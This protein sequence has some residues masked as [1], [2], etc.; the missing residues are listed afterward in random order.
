MFF[1]GRYRD[2]LFISFSAFIFTLIY[3]NA[4]SYYL[5]PPFSYRELYPNI[6]V[7]L[8]LQIG[9]GLQSILWLSLSY[10]YSLVSAIRVLKLGLSLVEILMR[11]SVALFFLIL[12][13]PGLLHMTIGLFAGFV[14][15]LSGQTMLLYYVY[16]VITIAS[17]SIQIIA[18]LLYL[19]MVF[20]KGLGYKIW[21]NEYATYW[22][23]VVFLVEIG[24]M[25][26][27]ALIDH[28]IASGS[29]ILYQSIYIRGWN[30]ETARILISRYAMENGSIT[31]YTLLPTWGQVI[32]Y[33][34]IKPLLLDYVTRRQI[35]TPIRLSRMYRRKT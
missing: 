20:R 31:K 11:P 32:S 8:I 22:L 28:L 21:A 2:Y 19:L 15:A 5:A 12:A 16:L 25:I 26:L 17:L 9:L 6:Q 4:Y 35:V 30:E 34:F 24:S 7:M 3:Y 14:L 18:P 27:Q 13:L 10:L 33:F 1:L 29:S 23:L